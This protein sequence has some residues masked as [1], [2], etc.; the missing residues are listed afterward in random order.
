VTL[1]PFLPSIRPDAKRRSKKFVI[2]RI[3]LSLFIMLKPN[4]LALSRLIKKK[5]EEMLLCLV[6]V[7]TSKPDLYKVFL[8]KSKQCEECV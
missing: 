3:L 7:K 6:Y 5:G 1:S 2:V 4:R 8:D